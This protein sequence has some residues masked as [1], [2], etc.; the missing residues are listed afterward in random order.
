MET[1]M[2][3]W[4]RQ[5]LPDLGTSVLTVL[6][7]SAQP[8]PV[9]IPLYK[10]VGHG[11]GCLL[12]ILLDQ[13]SSASLPTAI[14]PPIAAAI[15]IPPVAAP[16]PREATI[17][18]FRL[19]VVCTSPSA[20]TKPPWR[21]CN[22]ICNLEPPSQT[23]SRPVACDRPHPRS[24]TAP[25]AGP[26]SSSPWERRI[27]VGGD[28]R[29]AQQT[30]RLLFHDRGHG[31][32]DLPLLVIEG[33]LLQSAEGFTQAVQFH[34]LRGDPKAFDDEEAGWGTSLGGLLRHIHP[35]ARAPEPRDGHDQHQ[36][37]Q[38]ARTPV[39]A[40]RG[41]RVPRRYVPYVIADNTCLSIGFLMI[42]GL[43]LSGAMAHL[44]SVMTNVV[45][46]FREAWSRW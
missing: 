8:T 21:T 32:A 40:T 11:F 18:G 30:H 41:Q 37:R 14:P 23:R 3:L 25:E 2:Q 42:L 4:P 1:V 15:P 10:A 13:T 36:E 12:R 39:L 35:R 24:E 27:Q 16:T 7:S 19:L 26:S 38:G 17:P 9:L 34:V 45:W 22:F 6:L 31:R 5:P 29:L 46:F 20:T 33:T 28:T 44:A 43:V